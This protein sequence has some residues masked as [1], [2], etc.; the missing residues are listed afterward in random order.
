MNEYLTKSI[1]K[2]FPIFN[3]K[4]NK[5]NLHY[6]DSAAITQVPYQTINAISNFYCNTNSNIHRGVYY[7]SEK[8]TEKY[9]EARKK[10]AD[11]IGA[12]DPKECIFVKN[13]TEGINLIAN[14][15]VKPIIKQD[16]EI[17]ISLMEHHS[18]IVPWYLICEQTKAKIKVIPVLESG[19]IDYNKIEKL[20]SSKT[21]I[22]AVTHISNSIG[23]INNLEYLVEISHKK[24]V[25]IMIDG[26]QSLS[27]SIINVK[28]INCDFFVFSSHKI[29]GPNGLGVLYAKKQFLE[30][31]IPYQG[32]G[33]MIKSVEFSNI[34]WNDIPYKFEAGTQSI[35]NV[36][37]LGSSIDFLKN[38]NLKQLFINKKKIFNYALEEL[39]KINEIEFI[40]NPVNRAEI[41]SFNIKNIHPH[42]FGTIA[43]DNGVSVRAGNHCAMP[44]MKFFKVS[45]TIRI[46]ISIYNDEEDISKLI[47]SIKITKKIFLK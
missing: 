18:N 36:I 42:D 19:D 14:S 29:F 12:S 25:P 39:L 27:N 10:I 38:I 9:E 8:A 47:E 3:K 5:K 31:M 20:L 17:L 6:L 35:A 11:F 23:T 4:I 2:E 28:Q 46:S 43:N 15:F 33:D 30:K 37:A 22:F 7:I 41:L 45:A 13:T 44:L 32:G 21:K 24:N 16:E 40:G 1:K 34:T 26:A